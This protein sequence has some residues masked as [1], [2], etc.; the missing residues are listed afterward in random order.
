MLA[1]PVAIT[2]A[3]SPIERET[4]TFTAPDHGRQKHAGHDASVLWRSLREVMPL[5]AAFLDGDHI[6]V[7]YPPGVTTG[8]PVKVCLTF[9]GSPRSPRGVETHSDQ[10]VTSVTVRRYLSRGILR[11]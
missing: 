7:I 8:H 5:S 3:W 11:G 1:R 2:R 6:E 9:G 4:G 10:S